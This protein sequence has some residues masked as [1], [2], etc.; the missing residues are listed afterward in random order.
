MKRSKQLRLAVMVPAGFMLAACSETPVPQAP[1]SSFES[2]E[3]CIAQSQDTQACTLAAEQAARALPKFSSV[4]ECEASMGVGNCLPMN[5]QPT[6]VQQANSGGNWIMP[7]MMGYVLGSMNSGRDRTIMTE[8][9]YR[10]RDNGGN[11]TRGSAGAVRNTETRRERVVTQS[12]NNR[13]NTATNRSSQRGGFGST[14]S[15]RSSYGS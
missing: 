3:S 9:V 15:A 1:V 13:S 2:V 12:Q 11:W 8:P 10:N 5:Q 7:A 6:Y 4:A 14:S